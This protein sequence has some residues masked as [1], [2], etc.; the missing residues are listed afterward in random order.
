[1]INEL[2]QNSVYEWVQDMTVSLRPI[3]NDLVNRQYCSEPEP[4]LEQIN[5]QVEMHKDMIDDFQLVQEFVE[6]Y[7]NA[8]KSYIEQQHRELIS[9][10]KRWNKE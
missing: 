3:T 5:R 10:I 7:P 2:K 6:K 1:M 8:Y 9:F 4:L